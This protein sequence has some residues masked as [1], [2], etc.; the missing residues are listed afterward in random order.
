MT[1]AA[2]VRAERSQGTGSPGAWSVARAFACEGL[3]AAQRLVLAVLLARA[4]S[5]GYAWPHASE[6]ALR[7]SLAVRTVGRVV[8]QLAALGLVERAQLRPGELLPNGVPSPDARAVVRATL[9]SVRA[10]ASGAIDLALAPGLAL[11]HVERATLAALLVHANGKGLAWATQ[12]RLASVAGCS[13]SAVGRALR[14]LRDRRAIVLVMLPPGARLPNGQACAGWRPLVTLLPGAIRALRSEPVEPRSGDVLPPTH[15][16][17][18]PDARAEGSDPMKRSNEENARDPKGSPDRARPMAAPS[19]AA[20]TAPEERST[21]S[22]EGSAPTALGSTAAREGA[23][24]LLGE[25]V[26]KLGPDAGPHA[27]EVLSARLADGVTL[28]E[29]RD[30][31]AGIALTAWRMAPEAPTRRYV[32]SCVQ[33]AAKARTFAAIGCAA[34]ASLNPEPVEMLAPPPAA[35]PIAPEVRAAQAAQLRALLGSSARPLFFAP[36][37]AL[38]RG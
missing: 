14:E 22:R 27:R 32:G 2:S 9:G 21:A 20:P 5:E 23:D 19:V 18:P 34:A 11:S 1:K 26:S 17:A 13:V 35:T 28:R 29:L 3:N 8:A 12:A 30:A 4:D 38:D 16:Q 10:F 37:P 36:R 24:L 33:S 6:V 31:I 7:T 15:E 25:W